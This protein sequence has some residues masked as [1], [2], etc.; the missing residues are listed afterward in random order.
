M[1]NKRQIGFM[2]AILIGLAAGLVIGWLLIKTPI[3]NASLSSLRGD[4]Q[5]DYVLMVAEK[6]AV[7]QDILTATAL[8]RDIASSD[9]A[10]S[11]K[12]ALI[13]G[14][15]LGYSPRELQ[16][17]TLLETAVGASSSNLISATPSVEVAP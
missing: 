5:A 14:Q 4:Y 13:L 16:L 11:I 10:A 8:L 3:R 1:Q 7:D 12:N 2:I 6:F 15:Q 17:I 9:P